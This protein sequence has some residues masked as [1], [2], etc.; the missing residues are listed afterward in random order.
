[1]ICTGLVKCEKYSSLVVSWL[2]NTCLS[3]LDKN[4]SSVTRRSAGLPFTIVSILIGDAK[5]TL[6]LF[7]VAL[8]NLMEV[9][10]GFE[11]AIETGDC[12]PI[13]ALNILTAIVKESCLKKQAHMYFNDLLIL[14]LRGLSSKVWGVRNSSTMLFSSL[15]TRTFGMDM[16]NLSSGAGFSI[17]SFFQRYPDLFKFLNHYFASVVETFA[18]SS[19]YACLL[20]FSRFRAVSDAEMGPDLKVIKDSI[21]KCLVSNQFRIRSMASIAMFPFL[22]PSQKS[23]ESRVILKSLSKASSSNEINGLLM[24]LINL[25]GPADEGAIAEFLSQAEW[26]YCS[27]YTHPANVALALKLHVPR[28]LWISYKGSFSHDICLKLCIKEACRSYYESV[29]LNVPH[30]SLFLDRIRELKDD[31]EIIDCG[32]VA[33]SE[34]LKR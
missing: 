15:M 24:T 32:I 16:S 30:L 31:Y 22:S 28:D 19:V 4:S 11:D 18:Y 23:H 27:S 3:I 10:N 33:V 21:R 9:A 8:L 7:N 12:P 20:F 26:L 29:E 14:S 34:N 25:K 17:C 1:L 2:K 6:N 13:H 5:G